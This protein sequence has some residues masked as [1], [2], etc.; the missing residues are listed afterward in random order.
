MHRQDNARPLA[1]AAQAH[2]WRLVVNAV[3]AGLRQ[4]AAAKT[5][6]VSLSAVNKWVAIDKVGGLNSGNRP[7]V[8]EEI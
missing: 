3:R 2:L 1:P 5:Y 7:W 4:T 6:G 8:Y